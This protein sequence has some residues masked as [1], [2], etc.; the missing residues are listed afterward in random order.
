MS[1]MIKPIILKPSK[2]LLHKWYFQYFF[3]WFILIFLLDLIILPLMAVIPI[4]EV[5]LAI[6]I[7]DA[8]II[9]LMIIIAVILFPFLGMYFNTFEYRITN[10]LIEVRK[11]LIDK[12]KKFVPYRTITNINTV[13]EFS[14]RIFKIGSVHVETAGASGTALPEERLMGLSNPEEIQELI[15]NKIKS[16]R[17]PYGTTTEP[18]ETVTNVEHPMEELFGT[19]KEIKELLIKIHQKL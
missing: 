19:V 12:T 7:V 5:L 3:P 2:K 17:T 9:V 16:F 11:G 1:D 6:I 15:L 4:S 10:D 8:I 14:D 18:I 13:Y